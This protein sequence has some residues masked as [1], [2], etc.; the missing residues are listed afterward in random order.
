MMVSRVA[1]LVG[2][3]LSL[4]VIT[5]CGEGGL[6]G[7]APQVL[8]EVSASRG[9]LRVTIIENG[10]LK[11]ANAT[12]IA[13]R[14]AGV[15]TWVVD[16][17]AVVEAG[18]LLLELESNQTLRK[19]DD[20]RIELDN[21]QRELA[22]A[23]GAAELYVLE[24]E[25]S[26]AEAQQKVTFAE[27]ALNQYRDGTAPLRQRELAL[28]IERAETN[29]DEA[30]ELLDRLP[31]L[32]EEGF[33]TSAEVRESELAARER[34]QDLEQ[35]R[36]N[37]T[38]FETFERPQRLAELQ[39]DVGQAALGLEREKR[40]IENET[41]SKAAAV[42]SATYRIER[43][44]AEIAELEVEVAAMTIHAPVQGLVVYGDGSGHRWRQEAP[45]DVGQEVRRNKVVMRLPD[46][47]QMVVSVGVDEGSI[48]RLAE[49]QQTITRIE[50]IDGEFVGTVQQIAS[51]ATEDWRRSVKEY[52]TT[53]TL[54][55]IEGI[56]FRPDM[57]ASVEILVA[58][59]TDVLLLPVEAVY[60]RGREAYCYVRS[61]SGIRRQP[62]ELGPANDEMVIIEGG[63]KPG[64]K[65]LVLS[66]EPT[67]EEI[68]G[69]SAGDGA[70]AGAPGP[71]VLL[72][73]WGAR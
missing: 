10:S 55:D 70:A 47:S 44:Q 3:V 12:A 39:A 23:T 71:A 50:G 42:R 21:L 45:L 8:A 16:Q 7:D 9:D 43:K 24:S 69:G 59:H 22:E 57:S 62:L 20:R 51:T 18:D 48:T 49:G 64:T 58:H 72:G 37:L 1:V 68:E 67:D 14:T 63:L 36:A 34:E 73:G 26:L 66:R 13:A 30:V 31:A 35:A 41:A 53:V 6:A 2:A 40:K 46:L 60:S 27:M 5:G 11:S 17:G 61:G 19:L 29:R 15:I 32:L 38:V 52:D 28:A 33:V 4:G 25:R 56:A 54:G 65:A